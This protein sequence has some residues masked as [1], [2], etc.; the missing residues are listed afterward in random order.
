VTSMQLELGRRASISPRCGA[1]S[2]A[3]FW[4]MLPEF[5][6]RPRVS[7]RRRRPRS[8][9]APAAPAPRRRA[10][11]GHH[12]GGRV[13][14]LRQTRFPAPFIFD[15]TQRDHEQTRRSGAW[16]TAPVFPR[17]P[18]AA[19]A[20][21]P[22]VNLSFALNYALGGDR[23]EG[24]HVVQ[25]PSSISPP[26]S[27]LFWF[28]PPHPSA[29]PLLRARAGARARFPVAFFSALLWTVHPLLT[30]VGDV[31]RAAHRVARRG[32]GIW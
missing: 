25:P 2:P 11:G 7:R 22:L 4:R 13:A 26:G 19:R 1:C 23:V 28:H 17:R 29:C 14:G 9:V 21:R 31:P 6:R 24:Y 30:E 27:R 3:K 12:C 10:R 16:S 32:S 5:F 15:D 20:G 18:P 8:P